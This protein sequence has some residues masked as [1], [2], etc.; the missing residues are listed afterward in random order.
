MFILGK[1]MKRKRS[2]FTLIELMVVIAIIAILA[3]IITPI[4]MRARFKTYH[5]ACVQNER[6]LATALELYALENRQLYPD[7][8]NILATSARPFIK[9]IETCPST[10]TSYSTSYT[11]EPDFTEYLQE[12]PGAHELQLPGLVEDTYPRMQSGILN[13]FN[14]DR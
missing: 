7:D 2:G 5:S 1:K 3:A 12:C 13:Q 9:S 8:L 6:N 11:V 10:G 14:A 4:L